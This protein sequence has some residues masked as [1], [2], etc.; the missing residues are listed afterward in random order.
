MWIQSSLRP[1]AHLYIYI[2][3]KLLMQTKFDKC[4]NQR[5]TIRYMFDIV[6]VMDNIE[7][8]VHLSSI[9]LKRNILLLLSK[10]P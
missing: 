4:K 10:T 5:A 1:S 7:S 9:K 2:Y 8:Y 3:M 6:Y